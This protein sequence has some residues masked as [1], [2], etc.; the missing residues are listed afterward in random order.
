MSVGLAFV[1]D[2]F[3]S[4]F[5]TPAEVLETLRIPVLGAVPKQSG[6]T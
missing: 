6:N 3:D 2:Y 4:S 5:R 1:L